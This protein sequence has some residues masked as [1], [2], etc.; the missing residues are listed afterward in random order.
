MGYQ[1]WVISEIYYPEEISTGYYLTKLAEGLGQ[2]FK[3]NV[4]CGY[5]TYAARGREL[6]SKEVHNGVSIERCPGTTFNKDILLL[7]LINL[8]TISISIFLKALLRDEVDQ[9]Q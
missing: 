7:R 4:L 6:P 9:P 5:P 1:L 2:N 3:V 8:I